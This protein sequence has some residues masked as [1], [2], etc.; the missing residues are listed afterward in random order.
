[1]KY[2]IQNYI[3]Y[4]NKEKQ[5]VDINMILKLEKYLS[6]DKYSIVEKINAVKTELKELEDELKEYECPHPM[7]RYD[8]KGKTTCHFCQLCGEEI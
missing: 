3:R 6:N 7:K 5:H 2:E 4:C 1:M 8:P